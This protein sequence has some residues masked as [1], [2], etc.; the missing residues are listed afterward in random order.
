[1]T[2]VL[3]SLREPTTFWRVERTAPSSYTLYGDSSMT[4]TLSLR[5]W[6]RASQSSFTYLS[7]GVDGLSLLFELN[8][9]V[10][11]RG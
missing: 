3:V 2:F 6:K 7:E 8:Q 9:V 4:I 1:M 10:P 5:A 11:L